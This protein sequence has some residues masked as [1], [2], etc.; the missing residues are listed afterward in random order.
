MN[1][2]AQQ[3]V[4]AV[5]VIRA[6]A[7]IAAIGWRRYG[8][9]CYAATLMALA[10]HQY[11]H[12]RTRSLLLRAATISRVTSRGPFHSLVLMELML[13]AVSI[14]AGCLSLFAIVVSLSE[15]GAVDGA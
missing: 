5:L 12:H 9:A 15:S 4:A 6:A 13:D 10:L 8:M 14:N 11:G 3:S 1:G 2:E 7:T